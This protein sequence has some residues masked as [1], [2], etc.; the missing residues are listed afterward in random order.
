MMDW[1][2]GILFVMAIGVLIYGALDTAL[3]SRP[4]I[5]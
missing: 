4:K 1:L 2:V 3:G 5:P